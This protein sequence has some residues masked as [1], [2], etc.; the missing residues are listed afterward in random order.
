M[1]YAEYVPKPNENWLQT[2][3]RLWNMH[4]R[5]MEL[6]SKIDLTTDEDLEL[7]NL[8]VDFDNQYSDFKS[9]E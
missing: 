9:V 8:R 4:D 3:D 5:V 2:R 1:A 7:R 6:G